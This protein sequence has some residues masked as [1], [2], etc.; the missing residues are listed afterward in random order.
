[1]CIW[2]FFLKIKLQLF[3]FCSYSNNPHN[4]QQTIRFTL[5][6][7]AFF[8]LGIKAARRSE[9]IAIQSYKNKTPLYLNS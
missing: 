9:K 4:F 5:V 1:M 6:A 2:N 8:D 7:I 3:F